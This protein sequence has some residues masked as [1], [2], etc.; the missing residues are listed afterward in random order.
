M[1]ILVTGMRVRLIPPRSETEG[2]DRLV[3]FSS[4][5]N[6]QPRSVAD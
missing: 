3:T 6:V 2:E 1:L 4:C 5:R